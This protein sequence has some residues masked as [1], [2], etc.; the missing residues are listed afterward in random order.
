LLVLHV[1]LPSIANQLTPRREN[2]THFLV[3]WM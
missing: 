1:G 2:T 3:T